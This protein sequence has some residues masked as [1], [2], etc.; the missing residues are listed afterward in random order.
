MFAIL[1][2]VLPYVLY[3]QSGL[4]HLFD[5]KG[6]VDVLHQHNVALETSNRALAEEVQALRTD[7]RAVERVARDELGLVYPGEVVFELTPS[8]TGAGSP[9]AQPAARPT[10]QPAVRPAVRP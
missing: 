1:F 6:Q 9:A 7:P 4:P 8:T 2:A 10:V 5:L 3:R